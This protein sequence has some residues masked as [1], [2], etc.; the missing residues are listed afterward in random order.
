MRTMHPYPAA[1]ITASGSRNLMNEINLRT[2]NGGWLAS[3]GE[4]LGRSLCSGEVVLMCL[5]AN[6]GVVGVLHH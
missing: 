1:A 5:A 3:L 2:T 6:P 4:V